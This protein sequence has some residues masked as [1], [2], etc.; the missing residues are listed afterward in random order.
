[1]LEQNEAGRDP[2]TRGLCQRLLLISLDFR[3]SGSATALL[4]PVRFLGSV[5]KRAADQP[6][7]S[8]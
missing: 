1:M 8:A 4:N 5:P 6:W 3:D 7:R 2:K